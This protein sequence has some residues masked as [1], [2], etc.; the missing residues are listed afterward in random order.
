MLFKPD[1]IIDFEVC[2]LSNSANDYAIKSSNLLPSY[3]WV[4]LRCDWSSLAVCPRKWSPR[5]V[6]GSGRDRPGRPCP[7]W[8]PRPLGAPTWSPRPRWRSSAASPSSLLWNTAVSWGC[9]N[10]FKRTDYSKM[11][12]WRFSNTILTFQ[13]HVSLPF[14]EHPCQ[15]AAVEASVLAVV[16][17]CDTQYPWESRAGGTRPLWPCPAIPP[18]CRGSPAEGW[19]PIVESV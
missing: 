1:T 18:D 9:R 19:I 13:V 4:A 3:L 7:G 6:S 16:P 8:A 5:A 17:T 10:H 11:Q 14:R 2:I 12:T 15:R